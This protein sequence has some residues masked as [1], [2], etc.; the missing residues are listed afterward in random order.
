MSSKTTSWLHFELNLT[1]ESKPGGASSS[2]Q[3]LIVLHA[4]IPFL[5]STLDVS[6]GF[7]ESHKLRFIVQ[8]RLLS[9]NYLWIHATDKKTGRRLHMVS[10]I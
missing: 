1:T 9:V 7:D 4:S 3:I 6:R 8:I 10:H 5:C 2:Y